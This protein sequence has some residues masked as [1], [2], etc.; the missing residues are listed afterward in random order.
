KEGP[1]CSE[2]QETKEWEGPPSDDAF[3]TANELEQSHEHEPDSEE[4]GCMQSV[5][6]GERRRPDSTDCEERSGH[7]CRGFGDPRTSSITELREPNQNIRQECH[8][9]Q[10]GVQ[11]S[12]CGEPEWERRED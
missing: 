2:C 7:R 4:V 3:S 11:H 12:K 1:C 5:G 10:I 9:E 8:G 6:V